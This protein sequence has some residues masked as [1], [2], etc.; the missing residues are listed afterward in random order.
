MLTRREQPWIQAVTQLVLV[1]LVYCALTGT[2]GQAVVTSIT[3]SVSG[4]NLL[5]NVVFTRWKGNFT[6]QLIIPAGELLFNIH[7][8]SL[9]RAFKCC[10]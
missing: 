3:T 7:L 5:A 4:T 10:K 8:I 1:V 2:D 9:A 6:Y